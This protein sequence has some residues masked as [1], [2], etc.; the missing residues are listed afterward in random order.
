MFLHVPQQRQAKISPRTSPVSCLFPKRRKL[1]P[2]QRPWVPSAKVSGSNLWKVADCPGSTDMDLERMSQH[3]TPLFPRPDPPKARGSHLAILIS[4]R[5]EHA[6]GGLG[7]NP[8]P[9]PTPQPGAPLLSTALQP[10]S[11]T[12]PPQGLSGTEGPSFIPL[13]VPPLLPLPSLGCPGHCV[14][15]ETAQT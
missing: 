7:L 1:S 8:E 6:I 4:R 13:N 12:P 10:H 14:T 15:Q 2:Q 3:P 5:G 11:P 9:T